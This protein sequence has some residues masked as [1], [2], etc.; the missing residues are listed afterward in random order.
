MTEDFRRHP[1]DDEYVRRLADRGLRMAVVDPDDAAGQAAYAHASVRGFHGPAHTE[2]ENRTFRDA[3]QRRRLVAVHDDAIGDTSGDG[4]W[5]IATVGSW[6]TELTLPGAPE[7]TGAVTS[8]PTGAVAP[9]IA[10]SW[11]I[12]T[13]TV[14]PTHTRRGIA[15]AM[16]EQELRVAAQRGC[17]YAMLTVSEATL[18]GRYGFAP[19][20]DATTWRIDTGRVSWRG[21]PGEHRLEPATAEV[22]RAAAERVYERERPRRPGWIPVW[23][24]RW[25]QLF[26]IGS[27]VEPSEAK[28]RRAVLARDSQGEVT[29]VASYHVAE[30][31]SEFDEH[32]LTVDFAVASDPAGFS[33]LWGF[34]VRMPLV[35]VVHAHLQPTDL[36]LRWMLGD[37]RA[38][39]VTVR[40]HQ[41]VRILDVPAALSARGYLEAGALRLRV[42]DDLGYAEGDWV[43]R[44]DDAGATTVAATTDAAPSG[45]PEGDALPGLELD[46]AALSALSLGGVTP[47]EFA[48]A[49]RITELGPAAGSGA[50]LAAA[51]R[52]LRSAVV[53]SLTVW[54]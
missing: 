13:V 17:P 46:V 18:Y 3:L 16:L 2:D 45:E 50:A 1:I 20:G 11:A 14:S 28:A 9:R 53:P 22:A 36:P 32:E 34:F 48:A 42:H 47:H 54:Y 24:E 41:W 8:E 38:A 51:A 10:R 6:P 44:V 39:T 33:A 40:D 37:E 35:G 7:P 43:L 52:L 15:R 5:P 49:G 30:T 31:G 26:G 29:A 21:H 19:A 25:G 27:G 12:S 23:P 4:G